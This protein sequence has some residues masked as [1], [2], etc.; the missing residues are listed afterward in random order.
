MV[1]YTGYRK[2]ISKIFEDKAKEVLD[3]VGGIILEEAVIRCPVDTGRLLNSIK[4]QS[5]PKDG[6]V[7]VGSNVAYCYDVEMGTQRMIEAHGVHDPKKP[8]KDWEAKRKRTE[9]RGF[10]GENQTLP[11]LRPAV[12][13]NKERIQEVIRKGFAK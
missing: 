13:F 5:F 7:V 6:V 12:F 2:H 10:G 1:F 4:M 8:I 11:F 9:Q 3:K